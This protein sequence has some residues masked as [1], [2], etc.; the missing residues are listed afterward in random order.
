MKSDET[1]NSGADYH[2]PAPSLELARRLSRRTPPWLRDNA[3]DFLGY[4]EDDLVSVVYLWLVKYTPRLE[5]KG[6]PLLHEK[7]AENI[8]ALQIRQLLNGYCRCEIKKRRGL[9]F[10]RDYNNM[11][12]DVSPSREELPKLEPSFKQALLEELRAAAGKDLSF[13]IFVDYELMGEKV[14]ALA[15]KYNVCEVT[16]YR[17]VERVLANLAA[18]RKVLQNRYRDNL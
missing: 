17:H 7:H 5:A 12:A 11:I 6:L 14:P 3:R 9:S 2:F 15:K 18:R 10:A 4:G 16:I 13:K 8:L 1:K